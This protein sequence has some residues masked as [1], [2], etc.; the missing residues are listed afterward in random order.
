MLIDTLP[1]QWVS[2]KKKTNRK[3]HS[4]TEVQGPSEDFQP[5]V[6]VLLLKGPPPPVEVPVVWYL[7]N[8]LSNAEPGF[9]FDQYVPSELKVVESP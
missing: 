8:I 3:F 2:K 4:N 9:S 7:Q 1:L 6:K 5:Q